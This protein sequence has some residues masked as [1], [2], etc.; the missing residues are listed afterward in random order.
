MNAPATVSGRG[1]DPLGQGRQRDVADPGLEERAR[2]RRL[3]LVR[4]EVEVVRPDADEPDV[5]HEVRVRLRAQRR[6]QRR[7]AGH[8]AGVELELLELRRADRA[9][10]HL[11]RAPRGVRGQLD[12]EDLAS[13][14]LVERDRLRRPGVAVRDRTGLAGLGRV[15]VA[16]RQVVE[17]GRGDLVRRDDDLVVLGLA[18]DDDRAVDHA[19]PPG[20][21]DPRHV[22]R[23]AS[24][25]T[26][27]RALRREDRTVH[28]GVDGRAG[29]R[30]AGPG[31]RTVT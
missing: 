8:A 11:D 17:A 14:V 28:D 29:G 19:D 7:L 6:D 31:C 2:E 10:L 20:R 27:R 9:L 24:Q 13:P 26:V 12:E 5:E 25:R 15:P 3:D 30:T 16:E 21:R 1:Q 22:G 4:I 18:R 23:E